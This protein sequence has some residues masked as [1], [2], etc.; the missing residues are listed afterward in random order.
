M[1]GYHRG[2]YPRYVRHYRLNRVPSPE[3]RLPKASSL[4]RRRRRQS[5]SSS[6]FAAAG[7]YR[8][9]NGSRVSWRAST[10]STDHHL[11]TDSAVFQ[12]LS[13]SC[14]K[15]EARKVSDER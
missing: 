10:R 4:R 11:P 1:T 6:V 13:L 8:V 9:N 2:S 7:I 5:T 3:T 15:C 12:V 14:E